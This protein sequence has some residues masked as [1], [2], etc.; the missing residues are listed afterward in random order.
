MSN[1]ISKVFGASPVAPMQ[2][3]MNT[4]FKA[5]RELVV[6]FESAVAEDWPGVEASREKIVAIEQEADEYKKQ[7]R[8]QMP[9]SLFMPVPRED[10]LNLLWAQDQI[11]NTARDISGL[12]L[13]R[14]MTIPKP[15]REDFLAYV[16][17][18]ADAAKMARKSVRELDE[19][20]TTGFRGA[21][22]QFVE[23][24][25]EDLD[26]IENDT[27]EM[28]AKVRAGLFKLED[29]LPPVSV[30]FLYRVIELIGEIG[31]M[32]ERIGRRLE[33]LLAH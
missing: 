22:A 32:S 8:G 12:V 21:E 25:V 33:L 2:D 27:D 3:H 11:A 29:K 7:I 19:L 31:D 10:L 13:G 9:K 23:T 20:Y 26:R 1:Y 14:R 5:A 24:L 30:I 15:I 28:Q 6:M 18:N 16:K 4:C 17:R